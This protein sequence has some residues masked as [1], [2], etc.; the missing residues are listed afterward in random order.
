[1]KTLFAAQS[2]LHEGQRSMTSERLVNL[3]PETSPRG[4]TPVTLRSTPG[5]SE[6]GQ[7]QTGRVRAME[8]TSAGIYAAVNGYLCLW[9]GSAFS[10]LGEIAGGP[11]TIAWN[12]ANAG[13]VAVVA[14][15]RY[16]IWDGSTLS[17]V[18]SGAFTSYGSVA[19]VD[20]YFSL[21]ESGGGRL[22]VTDLYD[23]KT[24]AADDVATAEHRPD[25]LIRVTTSGGMIWFMG[26][27]SIEPWQNVGAVDFP[28]SPLQSTVIEKG[29]RSA[30]EVAILDNTI[31]WNSS[32]PRV[33]RQNNFAPERVSTHAVE[34]SME[35]HATDV[36]SFAYQHEGHDWYVVRSEDRPAWVYD[37]A[38]QSWHERSTGINYGPWEATASVFHDGQ[39]YLGTAD[40]YLCTLGGFQDRGSEMRREATTGVI[41]NG[42]DT[43][44]IDSLYARVEAGTG[45][46][47]MWQYSRDGRVFE[48]ENFRS[49]GAAGNYRTQQRWRNLGQFT[50]FAFRLACTDN[51][52]FAIYEAGINGDP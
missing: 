32:E 31:F 6:V 51:V 28:F 11:A 24:L 37:A 13:Q 16:W 34:A 21:T 44:E 35:R 26:E 3:Y 45:G 47:L 33:Y 42:G 7:F 8:S 2:L 22:T 43:F 23:G 18:S 9:N 25:N 48:R 12:G 19:F 36:V 15:T 46:T 10:V 27:R 38:T 52:D 30:A 1:M 41:S 14:G 29:I 4:R 39:W 17:E 5:L 40:G 49:V 20:G 50:D